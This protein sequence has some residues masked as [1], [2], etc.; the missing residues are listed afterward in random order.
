MIRMTNGFTCI[1]GVFFD[2]RSGEFEAGAEIEQYLVSRGVAEY[3]QDGPADGVATP[4]DREYAPGAG[5]DA[6][7]GEDAQDGVTGRLDAEQLA[8]MTNAQLQALAG[9]MGLDASKC[10][11]KAD[12]IKLITAEEIIVP[13]GGEGDDPVDDGD[14]PP[15]LNAEE[16]VI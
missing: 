8:A 10:R 16:P 4:Q 7:A 2:P 13:F 5:K 9:D 11:K 1:N 12:Y 14:L 3:A 15:V 6:P